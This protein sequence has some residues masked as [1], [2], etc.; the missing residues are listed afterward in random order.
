M[1]FMYT[2]SKYQCPQGLPLRTSDEN[3]KL[4]IK[5]VYL[6]RVERFGVAVCLDV[7]VVYKWILM[8]N[9]SWGLGMVLSVAIVILIFGRFK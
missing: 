6:V 5:N 3:R 8:N 4:R 9:G 7:V 2:R 1:I